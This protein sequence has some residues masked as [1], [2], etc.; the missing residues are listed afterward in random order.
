[1][2]AGGIWQR[3]GRRMLCFL[4]CFGGFAAKTTKKTETLPALAKELF[5]YQIGI[6][7]NKHGHAHAVKFGL[8]SRAG[9]NRA[10]EDLHNRCGTVIG[11]NPIDRHFRADRA[12]VNEHQL[13]VARAGILVPTALDSQP[14]RLH[15]CAAAGQP[16]ARDPPIEMARPQAVWAVIAVLHAGERRIA[17]HVEVA[18]AACE[19]LLI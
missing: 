11:R 8:A 6:A 16:I 1:M 7:C 3:D 14:D 4:G 12:A 10:I 2:T 5:R 9:L 13:A 15:G 18:M 17:R 19:P